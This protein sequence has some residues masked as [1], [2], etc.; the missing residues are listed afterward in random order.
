MNEKTIVKVMAFVTDEV[1]AKEAWS[2]ER[3]WPKG[4]SLFWLDLLLRFVSRQNEEPKRLKRRSI[5][6]KHIIFCLLYRNAIATIFLFF[7]WSKKGNKKNL[8]KMRSL[9]ASFSF[10]VTGY[11]SPFGRDAISPFRSLRLHF[12]NTKSFNILF[13]CNI[14]YNVL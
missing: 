1:V 3:E 4:K 8:V 14:I 9:Q 5:T 11:L 10:R 6:K 12:N 7:A 13:Q 2:T